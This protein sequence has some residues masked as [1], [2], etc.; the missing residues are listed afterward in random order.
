SLSP[1]RNGQSERGN[2]HKSSNKENRMLSRITASVAMLLA[3]TGLVFGA[4]YTGLITKISKD[5]V[6]IN[7]RKKGEKGKGTPKT[8]KV[9]TS[10]NFQKKTGDKVEDV[11]VDDI[12]TAIKEA[13]RAKGVF[14]TIETKGD[15]DDE[16]ATK[17]T[18]VGRRP[19]TGTDK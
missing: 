2:G 1:L 17:I 16:K 7:V 4:N 5:E 6:T 18:M 3:V 15:G 11:K 13:K 12:A 10:A 8:F 19:R 14:G 9:D